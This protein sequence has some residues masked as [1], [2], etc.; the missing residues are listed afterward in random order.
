TDEP[1]APVETK[2]IDFTCIYCDSP[3]RVSA[4]LAGKQ[5]PCPECRRIIK[6][7]VLEKKG[8][9]DWRKADVHGPS[10]ARRDDTPLEGAWGSATSARTVS[11]AALEE[12][13]A[14]P[15]V[16]ESLTAKQW[17]VRGGLAAAAVATVAISVI[18]VSGW[19]SDR[20]Q[21][22]ALDKALQAV[23]LVTDQQAKL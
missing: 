9:V 12:A 18:L 4:D 15:Q 20:A 1:A 3:V 8:P 2:T 5:T 17:V 22:R 11:R 23:S 10:G 21:K 7:P 13:A 14:I 6:V 16:K 19:L